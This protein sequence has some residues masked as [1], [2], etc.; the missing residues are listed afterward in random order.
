VTDQ[1]C[2]G[3]RLLLCSDGLTKAVPEAVIAAALAERG[4]NPARDLVTAA[5]ERQASDNVTAVVIEAC[6][7]AALV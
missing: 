3:E 2:P 5:L 4:D 1:L 7:G 6:D